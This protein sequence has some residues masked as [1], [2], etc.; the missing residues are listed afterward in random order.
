[1]HPARPQR[2]PTE[3]VRLRLSRRTVPTH[4]RCRPNTDPGLPSPTRARPRLQL[5]R[6]TPPSPRHDRLRSTCD[7]GTTNRT[8]DFD[9]FLP[10]RIRHPSV[11]RKAATPLTLSSLKRPSAD[12]R[13]RTHAPLESETC[14]PNDRNRSHS[15]QNS[16]TP[17]SDRT[18]APDAAVPTT[19]DDEGNRTPTVRNGAE[20]RHSTHRADPTERPV[21][22]RAPLPSPRKHAERLA[23]FLAW[24][25]LLPGRTR[26]RAASQRRPSSHA[27]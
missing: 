6:V 17:P 22:A 9:V 14:A 27:P 8:A 24:T 3:A 13:S 15:R 21:Q 25:S 7:T 4:E 2:R 20:I 12:L 1:M 23:T 18:T 10:S 19:K 11:N 26:P 5:R 16:P